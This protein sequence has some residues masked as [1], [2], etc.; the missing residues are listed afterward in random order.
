MNAVLSPSHRLTQIV[1]SGS[2]AVVSARK[3]GKAS[4]LVLFPNKAE[5]DKTDG[6]WPGVK[7]CATPSFPE[8]LRIG[9]LRDTHDDALSILHVPCDTAVWPPKCAKVRERTAAPQRGVPALISRE[10][11]VP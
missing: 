7:S 5:I 8:R 3:I 1:G 10:P 11:G 9:G 2:K 4:H 6:E